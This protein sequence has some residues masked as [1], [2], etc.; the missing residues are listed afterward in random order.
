MTGSA[1]HRQNT[2]QKTGKCAI[3]TLSWLLAACN[4]PTTEKT[5]ELSD[6][7]R[8]LSAGAVIAAPSGLAA[9][10]SPTPPRTAAPP[11]VPA[12][13]EKVDFQDVA[14][15][16]TVHFIAY[17][18]AQI[19][20]SQV[21]VAM[22]QALN[23]MKR[24]EAV[25][26]EWRDDSEVGQIN[27]HP[28]QWVHVGPETFAVISRALEE[29]KASGGA[30]DITFQAMSGVWK[31][32]S[33]A[34]ANPKLPSKA[35][36]ERLRRLVDY[37]TVELDP[38][39]RAVRLPK[40]HKIGLG[41]IA[42]GYIVDRA[43]EVL[44]KAGIQAFLVQAGGDLYGAGRKPDGS[45][46]VSGIMDPRGPEGSSFAS[47]ELTDHAFST[48]GDYAR[49]YV[50]GKRRYHH[51]IDPHTGYPATASRSVTVW[52]DDATTA[53]AVD[54]AVF[55]LGPEAG[56]KLVETTPGVG[57]VIVDKNNK[58][59]LSPRLQGKVHITH[60]PTDGI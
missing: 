1:K 20:S 2:W 32:G 33:A 34:E 29:G 54:D 4:R 51:I 47:I 39:A 31:F 58:V 36:V 56:L 11:I 10:P 6:A 30:F 27:S 28:E 17:T 12:P 49:S 14:M 15:G 7:A 24:L 59:W 60:Q 42:K 43:A 3:A 57:V 37:R 26:S 23:E 41:G 19:D 38:T 44:K 21:R 50:I 8:A 25:L 18:N 16:T 35:E 5:P 40:A 45:P 52:A 46:W 13:L 48:A 53:D 22:T 55:I 9:E